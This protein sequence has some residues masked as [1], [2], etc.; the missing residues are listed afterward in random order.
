M[1][2]TA[3]GVLN[4]YPMA[5]MNVCGLFLGGEDLARDLGAVRSKAGRE[6]AH[7][8]AHL[9]LAARAAGAVAIDTVQGDYGWVN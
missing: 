1:V 5:S 9:V 6:L 8:R 3:L 2:E 4:A 7:A